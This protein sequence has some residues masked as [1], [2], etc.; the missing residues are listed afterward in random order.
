MTKMIGVRENYAPLGVA[1]RYKL[2]ILDRV[3]GYWNNPKNPE[4]T[5]KREEIIE[6]TAPYAIY[7]DWVSQGNTV[8]PAFTP[9]EEALRELSE[10]VAG[11]KGD[12]QDQQVWL[13]RMLME[14]WKAARQAGVVSNQDIDPDV[15]V[16]AQAWVAKLDRLKEIDE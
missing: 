13:F 9:E 10:E 2:D 6:G 14:M 7:L 8:E 11:I 4:D 3:Y 5:P 1:D 15:L 16:K 12:L